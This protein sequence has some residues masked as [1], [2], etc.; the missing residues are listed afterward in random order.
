M[1][2][3]FP[4]KLSAPV[5]TSAQATKLATSIFAPSAY[6]LSNR[7]N[8]YSSGAIKMT[9][10]GSDPY[11]TIKYLTTGIDSCDRNTITDAVNKAIAPAKP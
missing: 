2:V 8:E 6:A 7:Y 10:V 5:I 1:V 3:F 9:G 4:E 11:V